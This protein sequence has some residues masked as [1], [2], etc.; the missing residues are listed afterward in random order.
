MNKKYVDKGLWLCVE[1]NNE[2]YLVPH[3]TL[4]ETDQG[5]KALMTNSWKKGEYSWP[6]PA[7]KALLEFLKK[8]T[9]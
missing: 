7:P 2:V 4:M 1:T 5:R 6:N 9:I 8:F 3:D